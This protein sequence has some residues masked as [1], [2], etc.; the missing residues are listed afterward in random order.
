MGVMI[1]SCGQ[2]TVNLMIHKLKNEI[3]DGG[4][5]LTTEAVLPIKDTGVLVS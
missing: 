1:Q 2:S 5:T 4:S 3:G